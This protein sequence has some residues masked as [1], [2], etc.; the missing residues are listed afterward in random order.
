MRS[1][2]RLTAAPPPAPIPGYTLS[3]WVGATPEELLDSFVAARH[4][5]NDAP[6]DAGMDA[7]VFTQERVRNLEAVAAARG[8]QLRVTAALSGGGIVGFTEIVLDAATGSTASNEDTVVL[9]P[10]RGRGLATWLKAESLAALA[11]DRPDVPAISTSNAESNA[12]MLAVNRRLGYRPVA[13]W[14]S[15]LYDLPL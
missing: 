4:A 3:S 15:Y 7:S 5:I 14:T 12:A 8:A 10:H 13:I 2:L 6:A 1:V 11:A 9:A